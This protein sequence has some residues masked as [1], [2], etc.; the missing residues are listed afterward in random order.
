MTGVGIGLLH[1]PG[2]GGR[3]KPKP[4]SVNSGWELE[5]FQGYADHMETPE[6]QA[7]LK[8]CMDEASAR[9]AVAMCA[10]APW[11]KCHRRILSDALSARGWKVRHIMPAGEP[12]EHRFPEFAILDGER[13]TYPPVQRALPL[14]PWS[15]K[16]FSIQR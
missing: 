4:G 3:R 7:A 11:W 8:V 15:G 5:A 9:R 13:V 6:F 14:D 10:E 2:L 1:L 12:R 16:R